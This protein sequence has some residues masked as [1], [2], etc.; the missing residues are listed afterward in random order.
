MP[1]TKGETIFFRPLQDAYKQSGVV[2]SSDKDIITLQIDS[3]PVANL[4]KGQPVVISLNDGEYF[5]EVIDVDGNIVKLNTMWWCERREYFRI[6]DVIHVIL[7]KVSHDLSNKR[8]RIFS[9]YWFKTKQINI[10]DDI[11]NTGLWE[12]LVSIDSKLEFIL[13]KLCLKDEG[14][15]N[16]PT[17]RVNISASGIRVET[18]DAFKEGDMV[19]IKMLLPS[20]HPIGIITYGQVVR[21]NKIDDELK[22]VAMHFVNMEDDIRDEIIWYTLNRQ[23]ELLR[24]KKQ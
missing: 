8:S 16:V 20:Y 22:E 9:G 18:N 6:D 19:E 2:V 13:E 24:A 5:S 4:T 14:F 21:V 7:N 11:I 1:Y 15:L 12:I 3:K 10:S 23:R 17:K